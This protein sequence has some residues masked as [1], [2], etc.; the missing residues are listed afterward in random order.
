MNIFFIKSNRLIVFSVLLGL[1]TASAF[2]VFSKSEEGIPLPIVMYHSVLNDESRAGDYIVPFRLFK[3]D[4]EYLLSEGYTPVTIKSLTD[5]VYNN[6]PLP[7]KP[8]IIT[9]DDGFYNNYEYVFPYIKEKNIPVVI[10]IVGKYTENY[11]NSGEKNPMYSYLRNCDISEMSKSGLV[12]FQN[13]SYN[14]HSLENNA[15]MKRYNESDY[16]YKIRLTDDLNKVQS[17][18]FSLTGNYPSAFTYPFGKIS[19]QSTDIIKQMGFLSSLSCEEGINYINHS[20]DCLYKLKRYN[21]FSKYSTES[22][23]KKMLSQ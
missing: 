9:L 13:H 3:E 2:I 5:Y 10:S 11:T 20:P 23:M 12:E 16:E 21:R 22:F 17:L 15:S 8:V 1:F 18:L 4:T 7:E 14:L 19:K 6:S